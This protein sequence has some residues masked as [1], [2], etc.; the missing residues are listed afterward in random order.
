MRTEERFVGS[1]EVSCGE[2]V[3]F[4]SAIYKLTVFWDGSAQGE[5]RAPHG[6]RLTAFV[7]RGDDTWLRL[8]L[9]DGRLLVFQVRRVQE[10]PGQWAD[11]EGRVAM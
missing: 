9:D 2:R 3:I 6:E 1:A 4:A 5:L 11:I 10:R 7:A 8:R